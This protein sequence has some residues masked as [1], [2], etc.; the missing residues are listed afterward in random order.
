SHLP[1]DLSG[2]N[3][4]CL[5]GEH[6]GGAALGLAMDVHHRSRSGNPGGDAAAAPARIA[7]LAGHQRTADGGRQRRERARGKD[8]GAWEET[9]S[10]A[11]PRAAYFGREGGKL[12]RSFRGHLPAPNRGDL[13]LLVRR[14]VRWIWYH[15][16]A[17]D[18][19]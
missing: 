5:A 2:R 18:Y 6:L 4:G 10:A 17:A 3:P 11:R 14:V 12:A 7:P 16:L 8:F 19:P 13:D 9:A 15:D 1:I